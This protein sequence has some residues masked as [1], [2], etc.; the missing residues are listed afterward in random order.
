MNT[1]QTIPDA[2]R[3]SIETASVV[4]V[5]TRLHL[6][7]AIGQICDLDGMKPQDVDCAKEQDGT[8][9]VWGDVRG[10]QFRIRIVCL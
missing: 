2:I 7:Q 8:F 9:D 1:T 10:D 4:R 5:E 6:H 3:E